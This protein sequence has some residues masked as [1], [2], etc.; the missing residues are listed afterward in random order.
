MSDAVNTDAV[1]IERMVDDALSGRYKELDALFQTL[2][3]AEAAMDATEA[4]IADA[5][6]GVRDK[7]DG[8]VQQT[9]NAF[10]A[11]FGDEPTP[12]RLYHYSG[13]FAGYV[14]PHEPHILRFR[15]GTFYKGVGSDSLTGA[16]AAI[17]VTAVARGGY[18]CALV[19]SYGV[20][21]ALELFTALED[22][23]ENET[24]I[25]LGYVTV[26]NDLV[27]AQSGVVSRYTQIQRGT[28]YVPEFIFC[29]TTTGSTPQC[30]HEYTY[31]CGSMI[32]GRHRHSYDD[33]YIDKGFLDTAIDEASI[34]T[35]CNV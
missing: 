25:W 2:Y 34:T 26:E 17:D 18:Y 29:D 5:V 10:A 3:A 24:R 32:M 11:G 28:V 35:H 21:N 14:S 27:T 30:E 19:L 20:A 12:Y 1:A 7:I 8:V 22:S 9:Q 6:G 15:P 13:P 23:P 4:R 33:Y 31:Y 16:A